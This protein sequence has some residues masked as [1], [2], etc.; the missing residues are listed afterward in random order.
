MTRSSKKL[1]PDS[2]SGDNTN[3]GVP[4]GDVKPGNNWKWSGTDF[5]KSS[6]TEPWVIVDTHCTLYNYFFFILK[7]PF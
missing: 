1:S 3:D 4:N 7:F 2:D 5:V 6:S